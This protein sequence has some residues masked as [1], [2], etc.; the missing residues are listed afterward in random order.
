MLDHATLQEL[1][2]ASN[3]YALSPVKGIEQPFRRPVRKD[4]DLGILTSYLN[5][6]P[7]RAIIFRSW[8]LMDGGKYYGKNFTWKEYMTV[9]NYVSAI[10][11]VIVLNTAVILYLFWPFR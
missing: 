5:N 8:G 9:S 4:K 11:W 7:D 3:P 6:V 10:F 2:E 1:H